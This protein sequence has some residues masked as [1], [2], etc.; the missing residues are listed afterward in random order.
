VILVKSKS[1]LKIR[2]KDKGRT[3]FHGTNSEY[4]KEMKERGLCKGILSGHRVWKESDPS[5]IYL[6]I[7]EEQAEAWGQDALDRLR[8]DLS[9][10]Y[11][12]LQE[13]EILEKG[14]KANISVLRIKEDDLPKECRIEP[15]PIDPSIED[16]FIVTNCDC[17]PPELLEVKVKNK[18]IRLKQ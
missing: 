17:I 9:E 15:D 7:I 10:L 14:K 13:P 2:N 16:M 1:S 4:V 8:S 11:D 6:T 18:W 12:I 3:F 5:Y